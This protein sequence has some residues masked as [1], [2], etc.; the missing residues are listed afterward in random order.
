MEKS[1]I[2]PDPLAGKKAARIRSLN[3]TPRAVLTPVQPRPK[4]KMGKCPARVEPGKLGI[5][6]NELV[7]ARF[8]T[9]SRISEIRTFPMEGTHPALGASPIDEI[10]FRGKTAHRRIASGTQS[11]NLIPSYR[12]ARPGPFPFWAPSPLRP[13]TWSPTR[14][15][16]TTPSLTMSQS[17]LRLR[18]HRWLRWRGRLHG[19]LG[20]RQPPSATQNECHRDGSDD[21][22]DGDDDPRKDVCRIAETARGYDLDRPGVRLVLG[23]GVPARARPNDGGP[24]L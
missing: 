17:D 24:I 21:D 2:P 6:A 9:L 4:M 19:R 10:Q 3:P 16:E 15:L 22:Y 5:G 1:R 13:R 18:S 14:R 8:L 7:V 23:A 20:R 12:T 11:P